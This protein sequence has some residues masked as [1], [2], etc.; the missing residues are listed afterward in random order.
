MMPGADVPGK[1]NKTEDLVV[2]TLGEDV[3]VKSE[4]SKLDGLLEQV[5][6][7]TGLIHKS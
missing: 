5:Q 1:E 6:R 4:L 7:M 3:D 2:N